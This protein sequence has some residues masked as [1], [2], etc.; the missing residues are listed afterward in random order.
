MTTTLTKEDKALIKEA[1]ANNTSDAIYREDGLRLFK[2]L[3]N[4]DYF[5]VKDG[6]KAVCQEA[7]IGLDYESAQFETRDF[8]S[9]I[10][11]KE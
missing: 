4:S 2:V 10:T 6:V 7:F 1:I 3:G 8:N 9:L 5:E 11:P